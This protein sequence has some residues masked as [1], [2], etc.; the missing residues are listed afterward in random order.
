[1]ASFSLEPG[2]QDETPTDESKQG[3]HFIKAEEYTLDEASEKLLQSFQ[4]AA[5]SFS[6][7]QVACVCEALLQAGNVDRL[8]R[9]LTSIPPSELL[10]GNETLLKARALVAF[11]QENFKEL[12]CILE[13]QS[14]HPSNHRFLQDLFLR[15]RYREAEMSRGRPLGPVDKY[16]L[17]KKYPLPKTIWDGEET[18][19]CFKERS[20]NALKECYKNNR[21]PT[22]D[23]RRNLAQITGLS[24]TQVSNWFKNKRQRD[25]TPSVGT[26]SKCESDGNHSTEDESSRGAEPVEPE[27]NVPMTVSTGQEEAQVLNAAFLQTS[28]A[29]TSTSSLLLNGTVLSNAQPVLLNGSA[30]LQAS[31]GVIINGL[32]LGDGQT[33]TLSPVASSSPVLVSG[34]A[35]FN[36]KQPVDL[37]GTHAE[38]KH[39]QDS[40]SSAALNTNGA[41]TVQNFQTGTEV[42]VESSQALSSPPLASFIF[43][44]NNS[45]ASQ[46]SPSEIKAEDGRLLQ[47]AAVPV[48]QTEQVTPVVSLPQI[49]QA[50]QM[51]PTPHISHIAPP[52]VVSVSQLVPSAE[53]SAVPQLIQASQ[54]L[55]G[56]QIVPL[57]HVSTSSQSSEVA[58]ASSTPRPISVPLL[59]PSAQAVHI[60]Q[61][62]GSQ[63]VSVPQ[64]NSILSSSQGCSVPCNVSTSQVIPISQISPASHVVPIS[65]PLQG[66]QVLS[67]TPMI[68]LSPVISTPQVLSVPQGS[69]TPHVVSIPQVAQG[70]QIVPLPQVAPAS[71]VLTL[72]Q[73]VPLSSVGSSIPGHVQ[74][75]TNSSSPIKASPV[76]TVQL[77]GSTVIPN[78]V[79]LL[80]TNVGLTAL[81]LPSAPPGNILLTNPATGATI[82]T[83]VAL[84]QGKLIFTATF[85]ASM[86][87]STV[88]S[89]A[90][91]SL[92]V[93]IKQEPDVEGSLVLPATSFG[94]SNNLNT[95]TAALQSF[96][97]NSV[98]VTP[99]SGTFFSTVAGLCSLPNAS[100]GT[101]VSPVSL[102]SDGSFASSPS[103][104]SIVG[105]PTISFTPDPTPAS[106]VISPSSI[107]NNISNVTGALQHS[108]FIT[109]FSQEGM[110][111]TSQSQTVNWPGSFGVFKGGVESHDI[112]TTGTFDMGKGASLI[113]G[114]SR[115]QDL[116]PIPNGRELLMGSSER[117]FDDAENMDSDELESERKVLTQLQSVPVDET[118]SM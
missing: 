92:T 66:S 107:F 60:S 35:A 23:E 52:H 115:E 43:S 6:G 14:F 118:L 31:S 10:R 74:I 33:V 56:S 58:Q 105:H 116:L 114:N 89:P 44:Q 95:S 12:Y 77:P 53:G 21:Y 69:A 17:R 4:S 46:L 5:L 22:P 28:S 113:L 112:N 13:S 101:F 64:V 49:S 9:F 80:G 90:T 75:L 36:S 85:P 63:V 73:G 39:P 97:A 26:P 88:S 72:Q 54:L 86:L 82:L 68:P 38:Q 110:V 18:M 98:A 76:G 24:L 42:K 34:S 1:M 15:A 45:L 7:E 40:P 29:P 84:H 47:S 16:R 41:I 106:A 55:S 103:S 117:G 37:S 91:G 100:S 3:S 11:H 48:T 67:P 79:Q 62:Q 27:L 57:S 51:T 109:N 61:M 71:Q 50:Q 20:R 81:Q 8:G 65:Q 83:G 108:S 25:R 78:N 30:V 102:N 104:G 94:S 59:T 111:L 99:V 93:P 32:T 87:M 70:S 2:N 96:G 19:Y